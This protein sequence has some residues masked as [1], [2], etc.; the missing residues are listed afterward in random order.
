MTVYEYQKIEESYTK[1]DNVETLDNLG[2]S[3]ET[4]MQT[5]WRRKNWSRSISLILKWIEEGLERKN[6]NVVLSATQ[7]KKYI[8]VKKDVRT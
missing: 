1:V 4:N 3:A 7:E 5:S 2:V 8:D 6:S